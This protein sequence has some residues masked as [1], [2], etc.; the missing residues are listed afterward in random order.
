MS[1]KWQNLHKTSLLSSLSGGEDSSPML[2]W[3]SSLRRTN[4]QFS[5]DHCVRFESASDVRRTN[6]L[7]VVLETSEITVSKLTNFRYLALLASAASLG[8]K[9]ARTAH[10]PSD[11]SEVVPRPLRP[12]VLR[13]A[14]ATLSQRKRIFP[15]FQT[16]WPASLGKRSRRRLNCST[17]D[18]SNVLNPSARLGGRL[19]IGSI[20]LR[21]LLSLLF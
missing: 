3:A 13:F 10:I 19:C 14:S 16:S 1:Q 18:P 8:L 9:R 15:R 17:L 20:R 21:R 12:L 4:Q 11:I 2:V 5:I 7:Q 6:S